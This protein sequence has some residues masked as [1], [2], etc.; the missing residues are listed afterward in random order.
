M[1]RYESATAVNVFSGLSASWPK[2][3]YKVEEWFVTFGQIGDLRRPV[4]HLNVDIDVVV[5]VPWSL[6]VMVPDALKVGGHTA[7]P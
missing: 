5:A 7:G 6:Y 3:T 4:V 1:M 2:V